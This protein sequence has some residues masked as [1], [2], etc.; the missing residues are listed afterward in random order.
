MKPAWFLFAA[1]ALP[2]FAHHSFNA[3]YDDTKPVTVTGV[4]TKVEWQN[5]HIWFFLDAKGDDGM[6]THWAFSGGAPG[7]LMRRGITKSAIQIGATVVVRGFR[8]KDGS[9]N[10]SGGTV[11]FPDGRMVFTAAAEDKLPESKK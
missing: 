9:N 8:A 4:V 2:V 5:P 11:T 3:E 6:V 7:Q 1:L 10:G